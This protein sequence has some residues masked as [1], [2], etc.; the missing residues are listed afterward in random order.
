MLKEAG[1]PSLFAE[2]E[3]SLCKKAYMVTLNMAISPGLPDYPSGIPGEI[4]WIS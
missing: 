4:L 3:C 1:D 2:S